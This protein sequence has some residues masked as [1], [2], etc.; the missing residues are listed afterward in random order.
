MYRY[1]VGHH[2]NHHT[3]T[4]ADHVWHGNDSLLMVKFHAD[5]NICA[6]AGTEEPVLE[7]KHEQ[8]ICKGVMSTDVTCLLGKPPAQIVAVPEQEPALVAVADKELFAGDGVERSTNPV[9]T[10]VTES[11]TMS[12]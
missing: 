2:V 9:A 4:K 10:L 6:N 11:V 5:T 8:T 7:D 1:R 3:V 12:K